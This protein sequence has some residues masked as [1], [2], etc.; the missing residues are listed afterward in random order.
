MKSG[1]VI[2]AHRSRFPRQS[3]F[4][5]ELTATSWYCYRS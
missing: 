5:T 4:S 1:S 2:V 3:V